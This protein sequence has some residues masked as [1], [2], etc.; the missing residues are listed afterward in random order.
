MRHELAGEF[1]HDPAGHLRAD[2]GDLREGLAVA[3]VR[4]HP[5]GFGLVDGQH[6]QREAGT[7]AADAEQ[8]IKHLAF[9]V[10]G[11]AE[12]GQR[13]LPHD[14][15]GEELSLLAHPEAAEGL[16]CGVDAHAGAVEVDH[17]GGQANM[18]YGSAKKTDQG[19]APG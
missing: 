17:G 15:G 9:V 12:Q 16:R 5:D 7:D 8:H 3:G 6:R 10:A 14:Q 13:V 11:E 4:G 18:R 2:A 19:R 1:Q